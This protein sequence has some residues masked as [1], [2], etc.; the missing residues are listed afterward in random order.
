MSQDSS[1]NRCR[2]T[3]CLEGRELASNSKLFPSGVQ[4]QPLSFP[5][6]EKVKPLR[7]EKR[8]FLQN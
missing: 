6:K 5:P 1:F 4:K 3:E 2:Q 7:S 8:T